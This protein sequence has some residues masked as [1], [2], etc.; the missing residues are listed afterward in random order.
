LITGGSW[1][2]HSQN[3][4]WGNNHYTDACL[5]AA[6]GT[7]NGHIDFYQMHTYSWEGSWSQSSPFK[8]NATQYNLNKPVVIGE[9]ATSCAE[10]EGIDTLWDMAYNRGYSGN[11][12]W[13]YNAGGHCAD[14]QAAQNQGMTRIKNYFNNGII[15]INIG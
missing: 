11:W 1:S 14:T 8:V 3:D 4:V 5:N 12:V 7:N 9:W 15:P 13:Q 2:E 6:G 10:N